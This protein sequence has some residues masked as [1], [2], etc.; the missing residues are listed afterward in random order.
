M[1]YFAH[2]LEGIISKCEYKLSGVLNGI[3]MKLYDPETDRG[4]P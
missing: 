3:D 2:R 1:A 4:S